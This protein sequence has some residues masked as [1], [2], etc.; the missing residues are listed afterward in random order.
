MALIGGV[1]A[2]ACLDR[3]IEPVEP[4][5]SATLTEKLRQQRVEKL[6]ILLVIDNSKSMA[7]KQAI[8][9]GA[10]A[11]LV[12]SLVNPSC[13]DKSGK[14]VSTPAKPSDPCPKDSQREFK[15]I[16]DMHIGVITSSLGGHGTDHCE[17]HPDKTTTPNN[18][19]TLND[20]GQLIHRLGTADGSGKA[21]TWNDKKFLV[22]DPSTEKPTHKP[23]GETDLKK[24]ESQLAALVTG[25]GEVGCGY[26]A[27]LE[28]WYRFA[29][30][31]DPH[32]SIVIENNAAVPKGTDTD[33][34]KQRADF[35]RPDSLLAIVML[36]DENDCS[37]RDGG[38]FFHAADTAKHLW[39][40]TAACATDPSSPCCRSCGDNGPAPA[41]CD[42]SKDD[43]LEADGKTKK[44]LVDDLDDVN[45]RC[46]NQK[47]RFG[48][49]ALYPTKRY[50]DAITLDRIADRKGNIVPNP[51]FSDL[52]P[53]DGNTT[54]RDP[55]LIFV[56]GIVG[57][58]WQD[59]ARRV[60]GSDGQL[61]T[62][63]DKPDLLNGIDA[64]GKASG[65][66]QNA[67]ELALNR[68]WDVI[69]G[70]NGC[71][72]ANNTCVSTDPLMRES[73]G[74]RD[75]GGAKNPVTG[76]AL[77]AP[78]TTGF[79]SINGRERK[80]PGNYDLQYACVFPIP[81]R[82][83]NTSTGHCDCKDV[84]GTASNPLC[85]PKRPNVQIY[86]KA[87]PGVR[88]LEVLRGVGKQ[89][90]VGSI[91]PAQLAD[92]SKA[93][94]GYRP[95]I[96]ALVDR[97]KGALK[98]QCLSRTLTPDEVTGQVSCLVLEARKTPG[99]CECGAGRKAIALDHPAVQST[100]Q[101]LLFATQQWNCYCEIEQKRGDDLAA[102]QSAAPDTNP[103]L[104]ADKK[105]V[106]GWCYIDASTAPPIGN[107]DVVAQ[108]AASEKRVIRFVGKGEPAS[109]ATTFITCSGE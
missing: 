25:A 35:I 10:V 1:A 66:F 49:D 95:A 16:E 71:S 105:P 97:L 44:V 109:G 107:P 45:V 94:Y 11:D 59:I 52:D 4:R 22:W 3:P 65:G 29:V 47:Q 42:T 5:T 79:N 7:D 46:H 106:D 92:T 78:G 19:A 85:D 82:D 70:K 18:N 17:H 27:T 63:D 60:P 50:V 6:D 20:R 2:P 55:S 21:T 75:A 15:P 56:A 26:E 80:Y 102:C 23:Q 33:L 91:C 77:V 96:G 58:P 69:L 48:F 37:I 87:Y 34:L 62:A 38:P 31:P 84:N 39:K 98:G 14:V 28:A 54:V 40:P 73:I 89:G 32:T 41:G 86:A 51:L 90:I 93:D 103:V 57:V 12:R 83:C 64:A 8:L 67:D 36:S 72:S 88:E 68:T 108:C 100:R 104:N 99:A 81:E 53:S 13:V 43:C 74:A 24:L 30:D 61:G 9:G 76:E 101:D